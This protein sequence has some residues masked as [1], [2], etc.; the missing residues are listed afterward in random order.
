VEVVEAGDLHFLERNRGAPAD[1]ARVL[2]IYSK[3]RAIR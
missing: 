1:K 3:F 2:L